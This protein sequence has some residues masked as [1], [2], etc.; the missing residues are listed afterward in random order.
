[1]IHQVFTV[2]D[3]KAEAY[4]TPF[5]FTTVGLAIRTFADSVSDRQHMFNKHPEDYTLFRVGA[6]DDNNCRFELL[7]TPEPIG[8]AIEFLDN[9][10]AIREVIN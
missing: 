6:F 10:A 3:G 4:L 1:M 9:Q 8:K 5:Y 2:Y 7:P